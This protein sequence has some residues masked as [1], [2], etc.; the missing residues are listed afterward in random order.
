MTKE[1]KEMLLNDII[2]FE[3]DITREIESI[4][5]SK[6]NI[7]WAKDRIEEINKELSCLK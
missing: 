4:R 7:Q 1:R 5:K 2:D 3:V 6:N